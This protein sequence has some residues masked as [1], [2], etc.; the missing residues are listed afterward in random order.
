MAS[1]LALYR[2]V[3]R[4]H[5][6]LPGAHMRFLGDSYVKDEFRRHRGV[7]DAHQVRTFLHQW[8]VYCDTL[9]AASKLHPVVCAR[10]T[11]GVLCSSREADGARVPA[12]FRRSG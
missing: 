11:P 3:L 10:C 6:R 9:R 4:V 12:A 7:Q 5:R 2:D 8:Q 1:A